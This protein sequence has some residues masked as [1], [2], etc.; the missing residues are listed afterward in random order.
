MKEH[1]ALGLPL[2]SSD[3]GAADGHDGGDHPV[4]ALCTLVFGRLE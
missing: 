4:D 2:L 1:E 3:Q